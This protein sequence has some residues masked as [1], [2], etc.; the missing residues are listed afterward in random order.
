MKVK[1]ATIAVADME[2]SVRFYSQILGLEIASRHHPRPG[3]NITLLKGEGDAMVELIEDRETPR[4]PGLFSV[5]MEVE[6]IE[7]KVE[8]LESRGARITLRPT[9]I[10]VGTIALLEDPNGAQVALIQHR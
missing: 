7:A 4:K 9:P 5:G 3:L 1:Y 2:E 10:T 6:D 8:E